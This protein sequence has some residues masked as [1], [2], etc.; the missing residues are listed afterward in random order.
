M[1][2]VSVLT[3]IP[4]IDKYLKKIASGKVRDLFEIDS[5]TLLFVATDRVSAYDV[6]LNNVRSALVHYVNH[7]RLEVSCLDH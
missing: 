3:S 6:V 1:T 4:D 5:Q 2:E 7:L